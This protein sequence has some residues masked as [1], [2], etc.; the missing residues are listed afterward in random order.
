MKYSESEELYPSFVISDDHDGLTE[1]KFYQLC[2][3]AGGAVAVLAVGP[4]WFVVGN[5]VSLRLDSELEIAPWSQ[6]LV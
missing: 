1:V 6:V 3:Y 5:L 4:C 2:C